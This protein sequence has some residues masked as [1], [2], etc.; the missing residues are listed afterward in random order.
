MLLRPVADGPEPQPRPDESVDE[1]P[2]S[3]MLFQ[4]FERGQFTRYNPKF[5][6]QDVVIRKGVLHY[7]LHARRQPV[8]DVE[9]A[10]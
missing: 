6:T 5:A 3:S 7:C 1:I 2:I 10:E 9:H 8:E 4:T